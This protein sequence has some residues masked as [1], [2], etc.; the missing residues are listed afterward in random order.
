[1]P[2]FLCRIWPTRLE[3]LCG[4]TPDESRI[5]EEHFAYLEGLAD[6]GVVLLAGRTLNDDPTS[7]GVVVFDAET[8]AEAEEIVAA[9]PAVRAG[10]FRADLFPFRIALVA[11]RIVAK[12]DLKAS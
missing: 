6:R 2:R 3:M 8:Q 1:M 7:F 9:D 10:V 12:R 11:D 4:A 5:V